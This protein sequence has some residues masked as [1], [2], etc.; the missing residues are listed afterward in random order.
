MVSYGI[1]ENCD[2]SLEYRALESCQALALYWWN[3]YYPYIVTI[4]E[5][6]LHQRFLDGP[7]SFH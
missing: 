6:I 3:Y 1:V 4:L 5:T 2:N 7:D